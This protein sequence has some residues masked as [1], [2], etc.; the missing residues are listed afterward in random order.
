MPKERHRYAA[1]GAY[2]FWNMRLLDWLEKEYGAVA[3]VDLHNMTNLE[4]VGDT[5]NPMKC[6]AR[7]VIYSNV[8][9]STAVA[10]YMHCVN[11]LVDRAIENKADSAIFFAHFG[12]KQGCGR[13]RL[14]VDQLKKRA[15]ISTLILELDA[16][17]P[18]V[19]SDAQMKMQ[20]ARYFDMLEGR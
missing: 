15:G 13:S 8:A 4:P 19:V 1:N 10:P 9:V 14:I 20:L 3:V 6:L 17:N 7:K 5:S 2:P 18:A 12:C 16:G 11:T